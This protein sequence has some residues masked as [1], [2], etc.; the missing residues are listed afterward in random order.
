MPNKTTVLEKSKKSF[1]KVWLTA[2]RLEQNVAVFLSGVPVKVEVST[3]N[4]FLCKIGL[5]KSPF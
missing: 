5:V 3:K 1:R 4:F 2:L